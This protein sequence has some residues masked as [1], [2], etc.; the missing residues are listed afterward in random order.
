MEYFAA[1]KT[2]CTLYKIDKRVL[3]I[4]I[5]SFDNVIQKNSKSSYSSVNLNDQIQGQC[6]QTSDMALLTRNAEKIK[7]SEKKIRDIKLRFF[8]TSQK[9]RS[10]KFFNET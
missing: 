5:S 6:Y 10:N 3:A 9:N 8:N 1:A 7:T 4:V 2:N